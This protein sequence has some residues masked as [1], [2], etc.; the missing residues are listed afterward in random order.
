MRKNATLSLAH[1]LN[2]LLG[3][4]NHK[5]SCVLFWVMRGGILG[6]TSMPFLFLFK[7]SEKIFEKT[8]QSRQDVLTL[9]L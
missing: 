8:L 4:D 3:R 6:N 7:Q 2:V 1:L 9:R 5:L